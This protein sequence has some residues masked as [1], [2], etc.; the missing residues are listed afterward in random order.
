MS[1]LRLFKPPKTGKSFSLIAME[2]LTVW[3]IE[4]ATEDL[5]ARFVV[6]FIQKDIIFRSGRLGGLLQTTQS[7]PWPLRCS[8]SHVVRA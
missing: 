7:P 6:Q 2:H 1:V 8:I 3:P 5:T 4:S